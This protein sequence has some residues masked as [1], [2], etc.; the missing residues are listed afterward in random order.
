MTMDILDQMR[1]ASRIKR[2]RQ[3]QDAPEWASIPSM[4][5]IRIVL[6]PLLEKESQASLAA[7]AGIEVADN[8]LG[9]QVRARTAQEWDVWQAARKLEEPDKKVWVSVEQMVDMLEPDDIDSLHDQ[10][11]IL[12]DYASPTL[13]GLS[14]EDLAELKNGFVLIDWKEL[15][16]RR[17]S[18]LRV[19]LSYLLPDLLLAKP[20]STTSTPSSI[21]RSE[22]DEST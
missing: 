9:M 2:I 6:V 5:E 17:W 13:E 7:A 16:G 20:A 11:S 19:C 21:T 18:A 8:P 12:M 15:T 22:N 1:E 14:D 3:G 10:L 4:P